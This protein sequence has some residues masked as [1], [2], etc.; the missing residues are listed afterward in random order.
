MPKFFP[1]IGTVLP[2]EDSQINP[3][4]FLTVTC[5]TA[6][7][8]VSWAIATAS[9]LSHHK[10]KDNGE[11]GDVPEPKPKPRLDPPT[12]SNPPTPDKMGGM[13]KEVRAWP[14]VSP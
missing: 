1:T 13:I 7:I 4:M 3:A 5:I 10:Y 6:S 11:T 2:K 12:E 8:E 9:T 14:R